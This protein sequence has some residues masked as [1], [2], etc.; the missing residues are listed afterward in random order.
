[1]PSLE[2]GEAPRSTPAGEAAVPARTVPHPVEGVLLDMGDTLLEEGS[3]TWATL[4]EEGPSPLIPGVGET[5]PLLSGDY[6]L[7]LVTNTQEAG[8]AEVSRA[9]DL[10]GIGR[11]FSVI[12]TSSDL[13]WRKPH[14]FIFEAALAGLGLPPVP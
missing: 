13:G 14:P 1:M 9:L 4:L 2:K 10:F 6:R 5:L 12:V 8:R 11:Y 7:G 3:W